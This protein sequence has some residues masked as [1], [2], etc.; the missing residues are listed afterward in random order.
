MTDPHQPL[1]DACVNYILSQVDDNTQKSL[2]T[3]IAQAEG[4]VFSFA[5]IPVALALKA[6]IDSIWGCVT[7]TI[8]DCYHKRKNNEEYGNLD[9]SD[10]GDAPYDY[11]QLIAEH[12]KAV[13]KKNTQEYS[14]IR[15]M[16]TDITPLERVY[17]LEECLEKDVELTIEGGVEVPIAD[18]EKEFSEGVKYSKKFPDG[19]MSVISLDK[20]KVLIR[21]CEPNIGNPTGAWGPAVWDTVKKFAA[22]FNC[23][24]LIDTQF[25]KRLDS[26]EY[27]K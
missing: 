6:Y 4:M 20:T 14:T 25:Q 26:A 12:D 11:Y 9:F 10:F 22:D 16:K 21:C 13:L 7:E 17:S 18:F 27:K 8:V 1:K 2:Y 24:P 15:Q 3:T 5:D 23:V 19:N